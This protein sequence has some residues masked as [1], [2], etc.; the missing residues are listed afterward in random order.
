MASQWF[1][2][3]AGH[4]RGPLSAQALK[5]MAD[6]GRIQP[7]D[8]VRQ[9]TDGSWV[10]A[11]RVKGLF[12]SDQAAT[13]QQAKPESGSASDSVSD[14]QAV[15]KAKPLEEESPSAAESQ[16]PAKVSPKA[17]SVAPRVAKPLEE[18]PAA[19]AEEAADGPPPVGKPVQAAPVQAAAVQAAAAAPDQFAFM[20]TDSSPTARG[21]GRAATAAPTGKR[22]KSGNMKL[23]GG[24]L[25]V[26]VVLGGIA[27]AV[28]FSDRSPE[29]A[30]TVGNKSAE[31]EVFEEEDA[32]EP[33]EST[34]GKPEKGD[35]DS[36]AA[37]AS[38]DGE[39]Q[40]DGQWTDA[41]KGSIKRGD[42]SV[43]VVSARVGR[44]RMVKSTGRGARPKSAA[45]VVK[46]ELQNTND[47]KKL[48]HKSWGDRNVG[49]SL[50]DNFDNKYAQKTK[51]SYG[52]A[53]VDGQDDSGSI[54][55]GKSVVDA[56]IFEPPIDK[57]QFLRLELPAVSFGASGRLSFKIPVSM[58]EEMAAE[59]A[60]GK[61][62]PPWEAAARAADSPIGKALDKANT[63]EEPLPPGRGVPAID[64]S[65]DE[66][67]NRD[68]EDAEK[69]EEDPDG[70]VSKIMNDIDETGGGDKESKKDAGDKE[71]KDP[72]A[73]GAEEKKKSGRSRKSPKRR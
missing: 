63:G 13:A 14:S 43:K 68:E 45:L 21:T 29:T 23:V 16:A 55:P 36:G 19:P 33:D 38:A 20:D 31:K 72:F 26:I 32:A 11:G 42:V 1:C 6:K 58:I 17:K 57:A 60:D 34:D 12:P 46:L 15:L 40:A 39:T 5:S 9:G 70:D 50:T 61:G 27:A 10:S 8:P 22:K 41:S 73:E 51:K 37:G 56:V 18:P 49:V 64:K 53:L 54:Y 30:E 4:E 62:P 35:P 2:K 69:K 24:L 44:P 28:V 71:E 67:E 48:E 47:T 25:A 3:I 52:G 65:I 59:S 66:M 7:D